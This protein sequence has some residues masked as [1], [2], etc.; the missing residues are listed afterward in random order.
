[1]LSKDIGDSEIEVCSL[2]SE[3]SKL[4]I[5]K[6]DVLKMDIEG[7]E[8]EAIQGAV[9]TLKS[10][11]VNV[12]IASYHI[13]NGQTTSFFLERYLKSIG[14]QTKSDFKKHLTTYGWK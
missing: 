3:L 8:I 14:Y 2:D 7:A 4:G 9:K 6:I 12:M 10:N 13:I 1:E 5:Q 11:K